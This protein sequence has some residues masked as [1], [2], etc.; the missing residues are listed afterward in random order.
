MTTFSPPKKEQKTTI[1]QVKMLVDGEFTNSATNHWEDN[2]NPATQELISKVPFCT[3]K[4]V[5]QA[6]QAA[7]QAFTSWREVPP[8]ERVRFFLRFQALIRENIDE[9]AKGLTLEQG[10]TFLDAKGDIFRGLEVVEY[11]ASI[12]SMIMGEIVENVSKGIDTYSLQ[13]P[14]G[15]CAGITPFNFPAMIPLWMYPLAIAAGN[16]F[17]L[18]PSEQ[19]PMTPVRI[20]ELAQKAGLPKGVLNVVHGGADVVNALCD[21][22]SIRAISF[23]GS[24][25]TGHHV[26]ARATQSGK[27][28]QALLGAKNHAVVMPDANKEKTLNS[29]VGAAFGASGQRC[30]ALPVVIFVGESKSWIPDLIKKAKQMKVGSG[31]SEES[32]LGP[33]IS[34]KAKQRV[35]S[36]IEQGVKE[37]ATLLLDGRNVEVPGFENGNFVGPTLFSNVS[38]QTQIYK[39]EIF[40]PVLLIFEATSLDDALSLINSNPYGNGTAIF[41]ESGKTARQ[42]QHLVDAGQVGINIPIPVPLPFFSFTGSRGSIRGDHSAYGKHGVRFYSQTK[43]ITTKW[44]GQDEKSCEKINTTI[45]QLD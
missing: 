11:A 29:I 13:Q 41:T 24:V 17:V 33:L 45:R 39:E 23:V 28:V 10:K 20:A 44:F 36:L 25:P 42:F 3:S 43:T 19:A 30:M 34:P 12:P 6:V 21:H 4:E 2:T 31:L 18:K 40:G 35:C 22:P 8:S 15:V 9:L 16:T 26:F 7:Q 37:G 27:R 5:D 38:R 1:P 14:L 32:D